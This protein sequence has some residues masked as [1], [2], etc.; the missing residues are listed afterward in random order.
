M[1]ANDAL[2][3]GMEV[4]GYDPFISVE[5]AWGLSRNVKRAMGIE[6]IITESDY[7][8]IHVPLTEKT[9]GMLN[10]DRFGVMKRG[11]RL[12]NFARGGLVKNDDLIEAIT[13]GTVNCYI[14]DF[15][16][17][18]LLGFDQVIAIPHLGASTPEAE[19]NCAVMAAHQLRDF[20][21]F[22]N[23]RN[24]INFPECDMSMSSTQRIIIANRNI[25]N[26]VGQITTLLAEQM[27]NISDM[28]NRH[29]DGLAY[30][31]IDVDQNV[32]PETIEK[33]KRIEGVVMLRLI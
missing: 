11:I 26:M 18:E 23:I 28:I 10:R 22:G 14:T 33:I 1:V 16:E 8:T 12:L 24:S 19:D 15:P 13:D 32:T 2:A 3:L 6:G 31:I 20:L 5:S 9:K 7:I 27:V 21:E 29:K 17:E 25:P 4:T 30:N